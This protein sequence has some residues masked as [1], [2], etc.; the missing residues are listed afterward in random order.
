M[1]VDDNNLT[2]EKVE[3]VKVKKYRETILGELWFGILFYQKNSINLF[4][5]RADSFLKAHA[6][7]MKV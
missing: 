5:M 3:F 6:G 2:M 7:D 1:V 4:N